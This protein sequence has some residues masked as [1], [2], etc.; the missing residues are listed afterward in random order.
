MQAVLFPLLLLTAQAPVSAPALNPVLV[1]TLRCEYA[2][3]PL[4]IDVREP[5]L[6]WVLE[7]DRRGERQTAYQVLV[8][9]TPE[10]L[11]AD[12]GDLWDSG[13]RES[14][15]S[16]F[17]AYAGSALTSRQRAHWKVRIWDRDK[18]PSA[19]STPAFFEMGLLAAADWTASWAG[20]PAPPPGEEDEAPVKPVNDASRIWVAGEDG[21][22]TAPDAVRYFRG[23]FDLPADRVVA[24]ASLF[25]STD[26][27]GEAWINGTRVAALGP[28]WD[29]QRFTRIAV[30]RLLRP[31]QN[32]LAVRG[33]NVGGAASVAAVV[34]VTFADG[35]VWHAKTSPSW[36]AAKE[37]ASGWTESSFDDSGWPAAF[38]VKAAD[39]ANAWTLRTY[40]SPDSPPATYL[41]KDF[42]LGTGIRRAR[43]Y[44]SAKGLYVL[45]LNGQRVGED[46]L[47]PGWTDYRDRFQYQTYDV[48]S[49][50]K[51][52]DNAVSVLLGDGWY[53][54]HIAEWGRANYGPATRA[55]VQLEIERED[56]TLERVVSDASWR[57]HEGPI[58][59]SDL[60]MGEEYDARREMPGWSTAGFEDQDWAAAVAEPLGTVPVVAQIGP[61]VRQVT[62]VPARALR[63]VPSG[64]WIFDLGQNIVGWARLEVEGPA[65]A[66]VR[67]RFVE[68]LNPDGTIYTVNLRGAR[69]TD[70]YILKG[71]GLETW[72]PSFT[73]HGFRYV[74]V[75]GFPGRP[76]LGSVTGIVVSSLHGPTGRFRTSNS[77][78][79]QLQS[80]ILWGQ[81]GNYLEVPTD[82][83]QRDERL[84][85]MGDAQVF[86]RTACYN[87]QV[88]PFL[89]KWLQDV[90]DAQSK[91]GAFPNYAP[92]R[93]E[94][95][96]GAPAWA[97]AGVIVPWQVYQCTGDT[98][99]LAQHY[100]AMARFNRYVQEGNPDLLWV[101]RS[102][103]NFGD[104]LNIGADAPRPVLATA[105][106]AHSTRLLSKI[107]KVLGKGEDAARYE[108]L[109]GQI[110]T[111]FNQAYVSTDGRIRGDTQ[112]IYLLALRYELLPADKRPLAAQHL[113]ADI[114]LKNKNHLSTG[115]L[116]VSQLNPALTELGRTDLAY[117]LLLNDTFPSWGYSIKQGA[118]TIWERWDG[119]TAEKGFQDPGMNSFN[120][121]SLGSVGEWLFATVAGID[122]DQ[123][124]PGGRRL[125]I[126]PRPGGGLEWVDAEWPS[127]YGNVGSKWSLAKGTF[128]LRVK[129]PANTTATVF[130]PRGKGPVREGARV[131]S[132]AE[133][134]RALPDASDGRASFAVGAGEYEFVSSGVATP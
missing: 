26:N 126:A 70:T 45:N 62:E 34:Q 8:A 42:R 89:T 41:R 23:S 73:T 40:V 10:E 15:E 116:G 80:N 79:N 29:W 88:A 28:A 84:G 60:L 102:G 47:R 65:G 69:A 16:A 129:V 130:I 9:S 81:R 78:V 67:L 93:N 11:A 100:E 124:A 59:M 20:L 76:R 5:R 74:E 123:E 57:T 1:T 50:L 52:G 87:S 91:K 13:R 53:A 61:S 66:A 127:L 107:A 119:W 97:D 37:L 27:K 3:S 2:A 64:A 30:T 49:L 99:I 77:M 95:A 38:V 7:S 122:V 51:A 35:S 43:I 55:L 121:Y 63:Q 21:K 24:S 106:F 44:A 90:R 92:D 132:Q 82:C 72:E 86:A 25:L 75:A 48:T 96:E 12:R 18:A 4:G 85:W 112:T 111:A 33:I 14:E 114:V 39:E 22:T 17:V 133:G 83:P 94:D 71:G 128:R 110:R 118:T 125:V 103:P 105:Y 68:M 58:R 134:V 31:G 115:F 56:G 98:R 117:R 113:I 120:H 109:F 104:W 6:S 36:R 131:A 54:G 32:V 19:W 108:A 101:K 46:L